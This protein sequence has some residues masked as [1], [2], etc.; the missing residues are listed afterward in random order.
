M[1]DPA[2]SVFERVLADLYFCSVSFIKKISEE[3]IVFQVCFVLAIVAV[4][5][6]LAVAFSA[7]RCKRRREATER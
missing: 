6:A 3:S 2:S 7:T 4:P 1:P 5:I